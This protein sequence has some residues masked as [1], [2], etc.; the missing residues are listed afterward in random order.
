[1]TQVTQ[2]P[3]VAAGKGLHARFA[4][5]LKNA[6]MLVWMADADGAVTFVNRKWLTFTGRRL[7]DE[8]GDGWAAGV[9]ADDRGECLALYLAALRRRRP[10]ALEYRLRRADGVYRWIHDSGLPLHEEDGTFAGYVGSCVDVT[11]QREG[12]AVLE[13]TVEQLRLVS[14]NTDE[15]IYRLRPTAPPQI[16]YVSPGVSRIIGMS[17]DE[18]VR[19]PD[20]ALE[21]VHPDDR[22]RLRELIGAAP[23][24]A[25]RI[26][27][28]WCHP[29]GRVVWAEHQR[30]P[31]YD[32][33]GN[34]IAIDGVVRDVTRQKALEAERDAQIALLN[35]LIAHMNDG[36]LAENEDGTVAVVNGAFCRIFG[37]GDGERCGAEAVPLRRLALAQLTNPE[38]CCPTAAEAGAPPTCEL[39]LKDGR[40]VEQEYFSIRL[41][42]ARVIHMWQFKDI[43]TRKREEEELRTSRHRVRELS[44]H[45]ESARE[46]ERR[47]LARALH[48]DVGQL[49]TGIRLEVTA[50]VENFKRIGTPA[51]FPVVDRL[52]AAVGL[53]D[54]S[55][56]TV[57][58]I[59][60]ALRPPM[61]DHMGI[62]SALRWEA[63]VFERRTGIR[64][65][66]SS[67]PSRIGTRQHLMVLYRIL[68]EALTNVARHAHAGTVWISV[69]QRA[70]R[71][72]MEVRDNGRG[73]TDEAIASPHTMGLLGIRERALAAGGEVRISRVRSGGTRLLVS[74]PLAPGADAD[75]GTDVTD[76]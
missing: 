76:G 24:P 43:T 4:K 63:A 12:T 55:I 49:L 50:A 45:L 75:T 68:L 10:F 21:R 37:I 31:V 9:H 18:F 32:S 26:T 73:I 39:R 15:M 42:D 36:V 66:V 38:E 46:Q 65:R 71:L 51:G 14:V 8:L 7:C 33:S 19:S 59:T 54:L 11:E 2:P 6:P 20:D 3:V 67:R 5:V 44:A 16:E 53:V 27:I 64:C 48:D 40:T 57:Q 62:L 74:L 35:G 47:D 58:R 17:P 28:R 30:L 41:E 52:Q 60:T 72:T 70:T 13:R 56:A 25:A 34:V 61:M 23:D 29:D 1:M 69:R 22:P